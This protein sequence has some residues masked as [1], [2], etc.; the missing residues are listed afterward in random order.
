[1][2]NSRFDIDAYL[3]RVGINSS[4]SLTE[5]G[6]ELLHRA[7]V[8]T[9]PFENFDIIL[10]KGI[11][12]D[13]ISLFNKMVLAQR[14]GYCFELNGLF[15]QV[16]QGLGFQCRPLLARVQLTD[17]PGSRTHQLTQILIG[18]RPWIADVGFG[19]N[20][21]RAPIPLE[22][23][24]IH[25]QDSNSYRLVNADPWGTM[26]QILE[27]DGWANLYSFDMAHVSHADIEMG[28]HYTSTHPS[29]FFTYSRIA[30]LPNLNGI[31]TLM[32]YT[33]NEIEG[34]TKI[35]TTIKSGSSYLEMLSDKFGITIEP[36]PTNL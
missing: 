3:E 34:D 2:N 15:L 13:A 25:Q 32:D 29:S 19:N 22:L 26:L 36:T 17:E 8:Y 10:G 7:Q 4:V 9:I 28:N 12:L 24:T 16:I 5:D 35:T 27:D 30:A 11:Q 14:G 23:E 18:N 1:M 21:L 20:G 6:L 31:T 33:L